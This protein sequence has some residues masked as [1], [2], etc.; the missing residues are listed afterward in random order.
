MHTDDI[1]F[2]FDQSFRNL[3]VVLFFY[4]AHSHPH[5]QMGGKPCRRNGTHAIEENIRRHLE[6]DAK[7]T[8][9][10]LTLNLVYENGQWW[11]MPEQ[12]LLRAISGGILK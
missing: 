7:Q 11:I 10:E 1:F 12:D 8:S 6:Q 4:C 5:N 2:H 9:W 3:T